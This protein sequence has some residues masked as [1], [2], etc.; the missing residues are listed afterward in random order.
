MSSGHSFYLNYFHF[1]LSPIPGSSSKDRLLDEGV[2]ILV[3]VT[4][5]RSGISFIPSTSKDSS[6]SYKKLKI[7]SLQIA[8]IFS[9]PI[10]KISCLIQLKANWMVN[11]DYSGT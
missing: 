9:I 11:G 10:F 4:S 3:T 5:Y 8:L 7:K 6:K 2:L 1:Y